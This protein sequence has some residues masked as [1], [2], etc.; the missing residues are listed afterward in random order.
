MN[1]KDATKI[2]AAKAQAQSKTQKRAQV[3]ANNKGERDDDDDDDE[4]PTKKRQIVRLASGKA[5]LTVIVDDDDG[6]IKWL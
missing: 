4:N 3:N 1:L 2:K 6:E 5:F